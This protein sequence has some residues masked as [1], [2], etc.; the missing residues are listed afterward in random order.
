M[1][2]PEIGDRREILACAEWGAIARRQAEVDDLNLLLL[3]ADSHDGDPQAEPGATSVRKGG[4]RLVSVGG[5]GTPQVMDLCFAEMAIARQT[6]ETATRNAT[7]DALDLRHRLPQLWSHVQ[8]L[9]CETWAARKIA[10]MTRRL[11]RSAAALV[12][13]AVSDAVDQ[14]PSRLLT[15]AE[16]KVI[17]ADQPAHEARL[18]E[19]ATRLGVWFPQP[20]PGS[21]IDDVDNTAG[22]RTVF[23][24][25]DPAD[26]HDL[27]Q[28]VED[29]AALLAERGEFADDEQPTWDQLRAQSLGLLAHPADAL[30]LMSGDDAP[31]ETRPRRRATVVVHLSESTFSGEQAGIARAEHLGPILLGQLARLVGHRNIDVL[32]VVDLRET[33]SVNGYEH[34]TDVRTRSCLRT[35]GDVFPHSGSRPEAVVDHDHAVP[36]SDNG[37]PGQT[38]DHNDAPLSRRHHRA[39]TH[40]GYQVD[41][42]A[43]GVYRWRSPNGLERM[44]T[45]RGTV[46]AEFIRDDTG[47]IHGEFLPDPLGIRLEY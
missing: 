29:L 33:R 41:Q 36:Y 10:R 40:L 20:P 23:G 21:D 2:T 37:P 25:L 7:A 22:L 16:A 39:K 45:P 24:R 34:P 5:D 9:R 38:G 19:N 26:A 17:E 27:E 11:D 30:A 43:P 13:Q 42:P 28:T 12:D 6:G 14:S 47:A 46:R 1:L 18:R 31:A 32:P 3:W 35:L 8:G 44:V 4:P 15:L